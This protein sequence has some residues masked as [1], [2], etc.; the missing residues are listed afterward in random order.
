MHEI[1][2]NVHVYTQVF[3][4]HCLLQCIQLHVSCLEIGATLHILTTL[5]LTLLIDSCSPPGK[6]RLISALA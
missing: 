6:R 3:P 2:K 4:F 1:M 5:D